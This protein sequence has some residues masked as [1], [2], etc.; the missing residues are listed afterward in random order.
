MK[1]G[2]IP[3]GARG[4]VVPSSDPGRRAPGL[5]PSGSESA[6]GLKQHCCS[7]KHDHLSPGQR[8]R[9]NINNAMIDLSSHNRSYVVWL[10]LAR[11]SGM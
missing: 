3:I 11:R 10:V 9:V 1:L 5:Y 2:S 4:R 8:V 7:S 6:C